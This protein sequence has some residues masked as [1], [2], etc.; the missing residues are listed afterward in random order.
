MGCIHRRP[1]RKEPVD[2]LER[3]SPTPYSLHSVPGSLCVGGALG[4][5]G[6]LLTGGQCE[7]LDPFKGQKALGHVIFRE[8]E[9]LCSEDAGLG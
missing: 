6:L 7:Q 2:T 4:D 8:E 9:A 5:K 1:L 3:H